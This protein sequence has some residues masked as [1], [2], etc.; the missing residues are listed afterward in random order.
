MCHFGKILVTSM[1]SANAIF[2][3]EFRQFVKIHSA[4]L[5]G[6]FPLCVEPFAVLIR[7]QTV[8]YIFKHRCPIFCCIHFPLKM[9]IEALTSSSSYSTQ[10]Y[11][12]SIII[13]KIICSAKIYYDKGRGWSKGA[14]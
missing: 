7:T 10:V 4:F 8:K 14:G 11:L 9:L 5:F 1:I 2:F 3:Q 6:H 12:S 13:E